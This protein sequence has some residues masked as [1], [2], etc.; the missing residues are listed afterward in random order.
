MIAMYKKSLVGDLPSGQT[1]G[2]LA[3]HDSSS[4]QICKKPVDSFEKLKTI[5][6]KESL[7]PTTEHHFCLATTLIDLLNSEAHYYIKAFAKKF[8]LLALS[9][10]L[11]LH[12][13]VLPHNPT[14]GVARNFSPTPLL[15]SGIKLAA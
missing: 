7:K 2:L 15:R 9:A 14:D 13:C 1:W 6:E 3:G 8:L 11:F 5:R 12:S 4:A 10:C